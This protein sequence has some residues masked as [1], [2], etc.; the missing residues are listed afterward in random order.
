MEVKVLR[1]LSSTA[2]SVVGVA[3][4]DRD[5][6]RVASVAEDERLAGLAAMQK[7]EVLLTQK[8]SRQ[9]DVTPRFGGR[10]ENCGEGLRREEL[11]GLGCDW[12]RTRTTSKGVTMR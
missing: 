8:T 9:Q 6:L 5:G 12:R 4:E 11:E 2:Q 7:G 10:L 3:V 1:R